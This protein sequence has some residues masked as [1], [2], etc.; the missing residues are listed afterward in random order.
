[1]RDVL[2]KELL[3]TLNGIKKKEGMRWVDKWVKEHPG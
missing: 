1:M 3:L 2:K